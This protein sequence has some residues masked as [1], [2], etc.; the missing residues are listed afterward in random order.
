M[1]C[2]IIIKDCTILTKD[3]EPLEHMSVAVGN[4]KILAVRP[5]GEVE[6]EYE[7]PKV[8]EGTGKLLMP[9]FNDAH[10]HTCQQLLR[11][12][13]AD[14][15]PMIWTRF[16]VPFESN[17][18]PE[19]VRVSAD[20]HCLE[21][22]KA[23]FTGFADAG[24]VHMDQVAEAVIDCGMRAAITKSTMDSGPAITD[25]MKES[26][27]DNI[28]HTEELY[29]AYQG[30]G[31][32]RVDIWFG[33][34]QVMT[35]S[36]KLVQLVGE[37]AAEYHTGIH[38]HLCE[39]K[40]EVSFC[41]QNYKMRPAEFLDKMGVLGP[42]LLTAHN[43]LLSEHDI[44]LMAEKDVKAVHCPR[45]NFSSHGFP[46]TPRM[47][48]CG[49]NIGI[50][51]D[52]ASNVGL[53]MFE[54]MRILK[55]GIVSFWGLPIFDPVAMPMKTLLKMG[56]IGGAVAMGHGDDFGTIEEGKKADMILVDIHQP[57]LYPSQNTV[58]TLV[59]AGRGSDVT[60]SII[61]GKLIMENRQVLTIDEEK[62]LRDSQQHMREIVKRAGI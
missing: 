62:V 46:K 51:C 15:Y 43:V 25:K 37:K 34:R 50:G 23:G 6:S 4:T 24:G 5:A 2:D 12:R 22:I 16:L 61:N 26:C 7:A 1:N 47:L 10:T 39:H 54:E 52:G 3:F 32:G 14:E 60:D 36:P 29:K 11:G 19:D 53:D 17:L 59:A 35:C 45:S 58:N 44:T 56:T 40:D 41:L 21:M 49:M 48:E 8:L 38:A 30:S 9:G 55:Y 20:L 42:N 28:R 13:T 31:D 33:I 18:T 27:E 57:H